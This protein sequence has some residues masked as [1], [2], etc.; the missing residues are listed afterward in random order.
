MYT[1]HINQ[2]NNAGI[3]Y[4]NDATEPF[5]EQAEVT[6]ATNFTGTVEACEVLF[7]LLRPH[8]R[9]KIFVRAT[10]H[11]MLLSADWSI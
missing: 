6:V 9:Y 3:A 5:G 1:I 4:K 2:V 8:A 10:L 11:Y 7:P